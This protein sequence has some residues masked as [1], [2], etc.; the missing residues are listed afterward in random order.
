MKLAG[1]MAITVAAILFVIAL[2]TT[3]SYTM[4]LDQGTIEAHMDDPP[5]IPWGAQ[6]GGEALLGFAFLIP[7]IVMVTRKKS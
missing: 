5:S 3:W 4:S 7:G 6:A 2:G 1:G